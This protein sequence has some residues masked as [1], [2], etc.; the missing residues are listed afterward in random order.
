MLFT[1]RKLF[2]LGGAGVAT[3]LVSHTGGKLAKA[4]TR[5]ERNTATAPFWRMPDEAETHQGTWM[6]FGASLSIWGGTLLPEV[7]RNLAL[8]ANTISAYEPV[9]MLVRPSEL[10]LAQSLVGSA[11]RLV[12]FQM[13]DLWMRDTGP[14]FVTDGFGACGG[15]NFNFNGWGNKQTHAQDAL[16][17]DFVSGQSGVSALHTSVVMEGGAIEVDGAGT[18]ILTESCILNDN[19]NPGL[20]KPQAETILKQMIGL[21]KIIWLPGIKN[22]DITDAHTDFYARFAAPGQVVA[23]YEPDTTSYEHALTLQTIQILQAS[24]DANGNPLNVTVIDAPSSIRP[25]FQTNEFAAGY[26]NF[27]VCNGA[28]IAPEFGDAQADANAKTKL[29]ALFPNRAV[30]QLNIDGIAAGGG[31]IHCVTQQE[32]V[33]HGSKVFLPATMRQQFGAW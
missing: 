22:Q 14:V 32:I 24:T 7:R 2:R 4:Q 33:P 20:T 19:R 8:I 16:V 10:S 5:P 9:S 12:P 11:V 28:V 17:A 25:A 15:I 26:I 31:G 3:L 21:Q 27:Y 23:H 29:Q 30:I 13:D 1:R 6:A 18:A